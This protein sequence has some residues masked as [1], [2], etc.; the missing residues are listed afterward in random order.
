[1][2]AHELYSRLLDSK[3]EQE[4]AAICVQSIAR[5]RYVRLGQ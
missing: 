5:G 2:L 1:M 3:L 4:E